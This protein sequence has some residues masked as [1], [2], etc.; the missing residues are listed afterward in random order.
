M[1]TRTISIPSG[2][3][4]QQGPKE[5]VYRDKWAAILTVGLCL[6][7]G[8]AP[9]WAQQPAPAPQPSSRPA[10]AS[11]PQSASQP[12]T[13]ALAAFHAA[14]LRSNPEVIARRAALAAAQAR[15]NAAGF[16]APS[17]LSAEVEDVPS[18]VNVTRGSS[19]ITVDHEFLSGA[20]RSSARSLAS[21]EKAVASADLYATERRVTA[22][23]TQALTRAA[24]WSAIARRLEDED[25]TLS[26]AQTSLRVRFA[27]GGARY[28]DVLRLRTERLRVETQQ[29]SAITEARVA[30]QALEALVGRSDATSPLIAPLLDSLVASRGRA[31]SAPAAGSPQGAQLALLP[32]APDV[33]SLLAASGVTR[34]A[35]AL[36]AQARASRQF[37]LANQRPRVTGFLGAQ[38]FIGDNGNFT[39]GAVA[40]ASVSLPFTASRA[41]A[42]AAA[43]A[44]S[45]VT[46]ALTERSA[47]LNSVR[48]DLL[49]A[50]SRYEAAR[51]R[52]AV[53]N[54]ALLTGAREERESALA[55][56]RAGTL[57]LIELVDFERSLALAEIDRLTSQIDAATAL[58]DL[59][60]GATTSV[61]RN[62][63]TST[64]STA[65]MSPN[66]P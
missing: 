28:V 64:I 24:G 41:N 4:V 51:A 35:N 16:A 36:V 26:S 8:P 44:S 27:T 19:R 17:V 29:A 43:A 58:T 54:A 46:A 39:L 42:T 52:L 23:G 21:A 7:A 14:I 55:A 38:R 65:S 61:S 32:P 11:A 18:G 37:I 30:R 59:L 5:V 60:T 25:S 57:T 66:V 49:A 45:S 13:S 31:L 34:S 9:L 3:T 6:V 40:G 12:D 62:Q 1:W 20:R 33:D 48:T 22:L 10:P 53:Y 15:L 47:T 63:N 50:R 56:Y 2:A